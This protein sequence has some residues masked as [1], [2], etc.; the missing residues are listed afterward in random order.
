M[1]RSVLKI[2]KGYAL[3]VYGQD[4]ADEFETPKK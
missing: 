4:E 2:T 1:S 3:G